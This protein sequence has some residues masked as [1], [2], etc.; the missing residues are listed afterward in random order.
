VLLFG[1][2]VIVVVVLSLLDLV[3]AD[4]GAAAGLFFV[5]T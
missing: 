5:S 1:S 2:V 3:A 4:A